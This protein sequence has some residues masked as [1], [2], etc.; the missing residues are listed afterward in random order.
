MEPPL[1]GPHP[2]GASLLLPL[3]IVP[4]MWYKGG[5]KSETIK[6]RLGPALK[7]ELEQR[8]YDQEMRLGEYI[9]HLLTEAVQKET[10]D[11]SD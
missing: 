5:M 8:A 10:S 3:D 9:R 7:A 2:T 4:P 1:R 11:E 6:F